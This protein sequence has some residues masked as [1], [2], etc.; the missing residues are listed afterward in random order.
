MFPNLLFA[1]GKVAANALI[2]YSTQ[3][4]MRVGRGQVGEVINT[5]EASAGGCLGFTCRRVWTSGS[6]IEG[7]VARDKK[8]N[9]IYKQ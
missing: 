5:R 4:I 8:E 2:C 1:H 7:N 3:H 6:N 9:T